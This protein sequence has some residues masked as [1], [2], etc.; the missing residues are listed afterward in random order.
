MHSRISTVAAHGNKLRQSYQLMRTAIV[1]VVRIQQSPAPSIA[2][3]HLVTQLRAGH[4]IKRPAAEQ[5]GCTR[6]LHSRTSTVTAH[7]NKLRQS[8]QLMRVAN[9]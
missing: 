5:N 6:A 9:S 8:Y 2:S 7:G 3:A 1:P 4:R